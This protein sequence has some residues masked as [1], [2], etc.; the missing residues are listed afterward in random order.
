[1]SPGG[2]LTKEGHAPAGMNLQSH[3]RGS[4]P[5]AARAE[6]TRMALCPGFTQP[7]GGARSPSPSARRSTSARHSSGRAVRP[8]AG[9]RDLLPTLRLGPW[10]DRAAQR[11]P[12]Q[13]RAPSSS[14]RAPAH[15]NPENRRLDRCTRQNRAG[16][17]PSA[18]RCS[19][20]QP[21]DR[22]ATAEGRGTF[23]GA[24]VSLGKILPDSAALEDSGGAL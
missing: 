17:S 13:P 2:T 3:L 12:R 10:T 19:F 16:D 22:P 4:P 24:A 15:V 5:E 7:D 6:V 1:M 21:M 18:G 14:R 9:N 20:T 11:C 23:D 8:D